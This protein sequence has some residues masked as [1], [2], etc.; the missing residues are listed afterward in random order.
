MCEKE[1][2]SI[3]LLIY[4]QKAIDNIIKQNTYEKNFITHHP[5]K[6]LRMSVIRPT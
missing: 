5:R 4:L 6:L 3:D 2:Q 1:T